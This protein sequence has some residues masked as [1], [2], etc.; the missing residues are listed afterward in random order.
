V[1]TNKDTTSDTTQTA[2]T[3]R[4]LSAHRYNILESGG[5]N[6]CKHDSMISEY[7]PM[8]PAGTLPTGADPNDMYSVADSGEGE[9]LRNSTLPTQIAEHEDDIEYEFPPTEYEAP[10]TDYE[11]PPTDYEAPPTDDDDYYSAAAGQTYDEALP[12]QKKTSTSQC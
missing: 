3:S 4:T 11:A 6:A 8:S 12:V 7:I 9:N 1:A 5:S 2:I 10:P